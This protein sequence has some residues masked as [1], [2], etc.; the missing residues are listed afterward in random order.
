[1]F[2][3]GGGIAAEVSVLEG[4]AAG[5]LCDLSQDAAMLVLGARGE[6]GF[7]GQRMGSVSL[8][9]VTHASCPVVVVRGQERVS[10]SK[11]PV[12]AGIG[13]VSTGARVLEFALAEGAA[14]ECPVLAVRASCPPGFQDSYAG[15]HRMLEEVVA[16]HRLTFP[17]VEM[18]AQ[19]EEGEPAPVL[20]RM[21]K[22]AQLVAV[23]S[24]GYEGP[25]GL[26]LGSVT[27]QLLHSAECPVAV[28]R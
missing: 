5:R 13:G 16:I 20:A 2:W 25:G 1:V 4:S 19:L 23:G 21:S 6:G 24:T 18:W 10:G 7:A 17:A 28:V 14:R 8:S 9:V 12:V 15:D 3:A 22:T 27:Q 26:H 11:L